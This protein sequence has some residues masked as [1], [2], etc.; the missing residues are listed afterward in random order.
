M[1]KG[2]SSKKEI[3]FCMTTF[4]LPSALNGYKKEKNGISNALAQSFS[5]F[6]GGEEG[7]QTN[8]GC[9]PNQLK[10][11]FSHSPLWHD[12]VGACLFNV[13]ILPRMVQQ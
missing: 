12:K 1:C 7:D 11:Q 13:L 3:N 8:S 9:N 4:L 10:T 2:H 5:N 6:F